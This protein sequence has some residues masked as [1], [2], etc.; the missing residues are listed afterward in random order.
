MFNL[1]LAALKS[2]MNYRHLA[3]IRLFASTDDSSTIQRDM[4]YL[5]ETQR[6]FM[7]APDMPWQERTRIV[8]EVALLPEV[9]I[10][11]VIVVAL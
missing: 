4:Q 1:P 9:L 2:S 7:H 8:E 5:F 11:C 3:D 10:I 6:Q